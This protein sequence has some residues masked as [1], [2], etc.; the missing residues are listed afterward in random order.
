MTA[1]VPTDPSAP[2]AG[3]PTP[4]P[5]PPTDP[6]K[7]PPAGPDEGTDWKAM[8]RKWEREAKANS[9]AKADLEKLQVAAMTEQEKAVAA[10]RDEGRTE[11]LRT[12]GEKLARAELKAAAATAGVD[13]G[14]VAALIDVRQFVAEGGEVDEVAIVKAVKAFAKVTGKGPARSGGDGPPGGQRTFDPSNP[15][16]ADLAQIEQDMRAGARR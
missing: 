16:A 4:E 9:R 13:L 15:R 10:A 11:A 2:P 7:P 14:E 6:P 3:P 12:A 1:P 8:A 5:A